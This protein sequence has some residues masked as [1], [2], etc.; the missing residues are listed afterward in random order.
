MKVEKFCNLIEESFRGIQPKVDLGSPKESFII[1]IK[2]LSG[3]KILFD[4]V[5]KDHFS[6]PEGRSNQR[7][8]EGDLVI[9]LRG[10]SFKAAVF[11]RPK[12]TPQNFVYLLSACYLDENLAGFR[13]W[14]RNA[15]IIAAY[16]NSPVGQQY[17][18][19]MAGGTRVRSLSV[20]SIENMIVPSP[21]YEVQQEIVRFLDAS[22]ALIQRLDQE[23][24]TVFDVRN[25]A[26]EKFMEGS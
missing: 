11:E 8:R 22:E 24:Q 1:S 3:G 6:V 10:T 21:A 12:A 15:K 19:S 26:I 5:K 13:L 2:D 16:L 20:K 7:L 23:K 17:L 25:A 18:D 14:I 4:G 9:S